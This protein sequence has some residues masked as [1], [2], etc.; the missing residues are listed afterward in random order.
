MI[1]TFAAR[2]VAHRRLLTLLAALLLA[3][4]ICVS[5]AS[6]AQAY[7]CS[8]RNTSLNDG[9]ASASISFGR[10]CS[11]GLSHVSG[12]VRDISCDGRSARLLLRFFNGGNVFPY[13]AEEPSATNGCGTSATFSYGS[14][15][16]SPNIHACVRAY[17]SGPS[18]SSG[19]CSNL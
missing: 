14:S 16:A 18:Q 13:R 12:T 1:G 7:T 3:G 9:S 8:W 4:A 17:N 10:N 5:G 2:G 6:E 15:N 11:D 19:D